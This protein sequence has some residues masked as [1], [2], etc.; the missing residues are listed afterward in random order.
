MA[1]SVQSTPAAL[2]PSGAL[3]SRKDVVGTQLAEMGSRIALENASLTE[4]IAQCEVDKAAIIQKISQINPELLKE[5]DGSIAPRKVKLIPYFSML[6]LICIKVRSFFYKYFGSFQ[7]DKAN[8]LHAKKTEDLLKDQKANIVVHDD[9]INAIRKAKISDEEIIKASSTGHTLRMQ[10]QLEE[11]EAKDRAISALKAHLAQNQ[12]LLQAMTQGMTSVLGKTGSSIFFA[13]ETTL[14]AVH[15]EAEAL[16]KRPQEE[17]VL[18]RA[19]SASTLTLDSP[20]EL[21]EASPKSGGASAVAVVHPEASS[22]GAALSATGIEIA[23][24]GAGLHRAPQEGVVPLAAAAVEPNMNITCLN[25]III[26]EMTSRPGFGPDSA[27]FLFKDFLPK[28]KSLPKRESGVIQVEFEKETS[29]TLNAGMFTEGRYTKDITITLPK[30][31]EFK[32]DSKE[33]KINFVE[34]KGMKASSVSLGPFSVTPKLKGIS[35]KDGHLV[36]DLT[37]GL[38]VHNP[39]LSI[40]D[41]EEVIKRNGGKAFA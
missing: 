4:K 34:D 11:G 25:D 15:K 6:H 30:I 40:S 1:A 18:R 29:I 28:M 33:P 41:L 3:V 12:A 38:V 21:A 8:Y 9:S 16:L 24:A 36:F 20:I 10:A 19:S 2:V 31:V 27:L 39:S 13:R 5:V 7:I 14:L 37:I 23:T 22:L 32:L 17:P 35:F 26:T